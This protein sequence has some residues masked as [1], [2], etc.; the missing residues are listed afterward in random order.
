MG[1]E[2][3]ADETP[4]TVF[5]AVALRPE[6]FWFASIHAPLGNDGAEYASGRWHAVSGFQGTYRKTAVVNAIV[7]P[8]RR[9]GVC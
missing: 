7:A 2:P 3:R 5:E 6:T 8:G 4:T 1:F 9:L